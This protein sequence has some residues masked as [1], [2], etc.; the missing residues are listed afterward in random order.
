MSLDS[1][2]PPGDSL[3]AEQARRSQD[4]RRLIGLFATDDSPPTDKEC[5]KIIEEA[6]LRKYE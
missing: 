3:P 5:D 1:S 4:L 2:I 6:R